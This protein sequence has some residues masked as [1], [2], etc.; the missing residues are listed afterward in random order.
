MKKKSIT[1]SLCVALFAWSS[2]VSAEWEVFAVSQ[3]GKS[4]FYMDF[5]RINKNNNFV[6]YWSLI[7]LI[8]PEQEY[9]SYEEYTK[10]ICSTNMI[11]TRSLH[12][13]KGPMGSGEEKIFNYDDDQWTTVEEG[14]IGYS[15]LKAVC[16]KIEFLD[17]KN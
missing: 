5:S 1:A 12:M 2:F 17:V 15:Q 11:S 6:Y 13:H 14:S 3:N 8:E 7:D 16:L 9:L 4:T 10:G